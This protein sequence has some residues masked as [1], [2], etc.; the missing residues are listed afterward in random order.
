MGSSSGRGSPTRSIGT[1][2][3]VDLSGGNLVNI[4][5]KYVL[6]EG[7]VRM[8]REDN[9]QLL[10]DKTRALQ[11]GHELNPW[12]LQIPVLQL[13]FLGGPEFKLP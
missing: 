2:G 3:Q 5:Q 4:W 12:M 8:L 13:F 11:V 7:T 6:L 10:D 9:E 1:D